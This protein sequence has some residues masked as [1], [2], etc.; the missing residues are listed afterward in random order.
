MF[1]PGVVERPRP[2]GEEKVL[3]MWL[4]AAV[5]IWSAPQAPLRLDNKISQKSTCGH[6]SNSCAR[7]DSTNRN[8]ARVEDFVPV[9][10]HWSQF[11]IGNP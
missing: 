8:G 3:A 7:P 5:K 2:P 10:W 11:P 9:R 1:P 4:R 6:G